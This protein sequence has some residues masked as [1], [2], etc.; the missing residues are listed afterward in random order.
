MEVVYKITFLSLKYLFGQVLVDV[1]VE[2]GLEERN[3][4]GTSGPTPIL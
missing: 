4:T 2:D 3:A 1:C